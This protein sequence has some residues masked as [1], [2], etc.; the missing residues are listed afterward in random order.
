MLKQLIAGAA[1]LALTLGGV[2]LAAAPVQA[3][4][5][6]PCND[7]NAWSWSIANPARYQAGPHE[8]VVGLSAAIRTITIK[9]PTGCTVD[10]GDTWR[11]YN[12]YFSAE[13]TF[14]A[15]DAAAGKD[16]DRVSIKVPTSNAV[17]G[18]EIPVKLKVNDSS[19]GIPGEWDVADSN[20]GSLVLLR[21]TLFKFKGVSNRMDFTEPYICGEHVD[22]AAPLLRA[23]W[24]SK[25][26][27]GYAGRTV[28]M[29][30][31]LTDGPDSAWDNRFLASERTDDRGYVEFFD[32]VSGEEEGPG[33]VLPDDGPPC[34][35]TIVFRG[36]YGG[37][38]TSSGTWSNG[39]AVAEATIDW[40]KYRPHLK[41]EIDAAGMAKDCAKLDELGQEVAHLP[42]A[43]EVLIS[44]V[45]RWGVQTGCWED[46]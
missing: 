1:S 4:T 14:N 42:N 11:V 16:T 36:H 45:F 34:G 26:Y 8:A 33:G 32:M 10:A 30:Y 20:A 3:F 9:A 7:G 35:G 17:A 23:S 21:R 40:E 24:T 25:R 19:A 27:L 44:Y 38:R 39:D 22:G 46:D 31:R 37:N 18:D 43:T 13:G 28:R 5:G 29:E 6:A 12:R 2:A 41:E 15:E